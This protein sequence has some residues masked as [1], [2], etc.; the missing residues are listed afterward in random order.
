MLAASDK[1]HDKAT[2]YEVV[3][4]WAGSYVDLT[5]E[6]YFQGWEG[7]GDPPNQKFLAAPQLPLDR[8]RPSPPIPIS[9]SDAAT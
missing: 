1:L 4:L 3:V 9:A 8:L 5:L 6:N 7:E 2:R